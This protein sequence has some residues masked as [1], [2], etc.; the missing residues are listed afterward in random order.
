MPG[1]HTYRRSEEEIKMDL[2]LGE[3]RTKMEGA[4]QMNHVISA[5]YRC[6]CELL[7]GLNSARSP[8]P[9]D[10]RLSENADKHTF[11]LH[12]HSPNSPPRLAKFKAEPMC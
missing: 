2:G 11:H 7:D 8:A 12:T 9:T 6:F 5:I 4:G 1:W 3:Q 10:H